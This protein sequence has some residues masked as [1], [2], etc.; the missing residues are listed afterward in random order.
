MN[1]GVIDKPLRRDTAYLPEY[2]KDGLGVVANQFSK[3]YGSI[4]FN[5]VGKDVREMYSHFNVVMRKYGVDLIG[6]TIPISVLRHQ[7]DYLTLW[8][9][10][11]TLMLKS[12]KK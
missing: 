7:L 9:A 8:G 12:W 5:D 10:K 11:D 3:L 4:N 6:K 1:A 2:A